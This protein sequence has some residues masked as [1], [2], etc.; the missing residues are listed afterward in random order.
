MSA[1]QPPQG[2]NHA[3]EG[4]LAPPHIGMRKVKSLLAVLVGFCIWQVLRLFLP[5][6]ETH[7]IFIYIYGL[8]EIRETSDKTVDMGRLR[9][10]ATF[11]AIFTGLPLML[12]SDLVAPHLAEAWMQTAKEIILLLIGTLLVL[13][14]AELVGCRVFCGLSAAIYIILMVTHF[15]S[16]QY[17]YS[18]MRAV[19]TILGVFIARIINVNLLPYPP[20]PGSLSYYLSRGKKGE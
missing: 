9:I 16:S 18:I 11:T 3:R 20:R 7:P 4:Y 2:E 14:I 6:L 12:L 15:A 19:Q 13:C 17:L 8:I 5:E 10:I 1:A